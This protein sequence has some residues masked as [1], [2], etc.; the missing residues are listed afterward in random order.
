MIHEPMTKDE[1]RVVLADDHP[2]MRIGVRQALEDAPE[3][4]I[5]GEAG[6]GEE[7]LRLVEELQP[8]VLI[9][10][11]RMPVRGGVQV[12]EA[13]RE[14]EL[15]TRVLALS[16]YTDAKYIYGMQQAGA[17]GYVMKEEA[18]DTIVAA[19]RAV[20]R[21]GEW[22]MAKQTASSW[23]WQREVLV[24]WEGLTEREHEVLALLAQG[25]TDRELAQELQ[26]S[27]RTAENH[28][29]SILRKL[30]VGSRTEAAVW[31]GREG[32]IE[33]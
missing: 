8:D 25:K 10:D 28:V 1:I 15:P 17:Q 2:L 3:V 4:V 6:D 18:I 33:R 26:I 29:S 16:A 31:A 27:K 13:I 22:W 11:C 14:R 20:A 24:P 9:L 7:A 5:V 21:G 30:R 32:F 23:R 19:V 12:A